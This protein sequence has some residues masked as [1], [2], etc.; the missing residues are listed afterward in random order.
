MAR[1]RTVHRARSCLI[2]LLLGCLGTAITAPPAAA[3]SAPTDV[4]RPS[5][6]GSG[7]VGSTLTCNPGMWRGE[8]P[9][10]VTILWTEEDGAIEEFTEREVEEAE[11]RNEEVHRQS[12]TGLTYSPT[13]AEIGNGIGCE[14]T[15]TNSV[16][17]VT[18]EVG[19]V[20]VTAAKAGGATGPA[21]TITGTA[22]DDTLLGTEGDE[23]ICGL[24][25]NDT[26]VGL[27]GNDLLVGGPGRD[28][29]YGGAGEDVLIGGPEDRLHGGPGHDVVRRPPQGHDAARPSAALLDFLVPPTL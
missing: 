28:T 8:P 6:T 14:V 5:F 23:V 25:G 27:G 1:M 21:C 22:G 16:G 18:L 12:H 11:E 20:K 29:I 4:K 2:V 24:A 3:D 15:A 17:Y 19:E 13:K 26:I 9:P 10:K 7:V